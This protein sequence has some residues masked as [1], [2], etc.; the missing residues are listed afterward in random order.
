MGSVTDHAFPDS[1]MVALGFLPLA[2]G[3]FMLLSPVGMARAMHLINRNS[4]GE[5]IPHNDPVRVAASRRLRVQI[6]MTGVWMAALG[7][8]A[9]LR[10]LGLI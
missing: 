4:P 2:T 6:R 8:A 9:V 1:G 3:M 5:L 10:G 7:L